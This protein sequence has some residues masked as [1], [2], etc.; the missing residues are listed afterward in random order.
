MT[1]DLRISVVI[2]TY[3]GFE[4]LKATI[5]SVLQ[6]TVPAAEI[7]V[8]DDGSTDDS[9][10]FQACFSRHIR[11]L[12]IANSGQQNARNHGVAQSTGDWIALLDHDDLWEPRYLA[13]VNAIVAAHAVDITICNSRTWQ[14]DQG[15][16]FWK[17]SNRFTQF[18]PDDYWRIVGASPDDRWSSLSRYDFA[19]YLN[20]HPAQT[21]MYCIRKSLYLS[22]G[23][24]DTRMRG[25]G[26][27]NFE[28]EMRALR[29]GRVGLIWDPLVTMCRHD[30]NAS[31]DG[32]R[33]TMDFVACLEFALHHHGLNA[34]ERA[35][36]QSVLHKRL[37]NAIDGAFTLG[38]YADIRRYRRQYRGRLPF[39]TA[40]KSAISE[41]PEALA[42][43][44]AGI[45]QE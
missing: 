12:K 25:S 28:F 38:K 36:V 33:M 8:I 24:F 29:A 42:R 40:L 9:T 4:R 16:G 5:N 23:G 2:P 19:S 1:N 17:D 34:G 35:I 32:N 11:Y 15:G 3:N 27:E 45:F 39:R 31:L 13:E 26:A 44:V 41:L 21:S 20:F 22:L 30:M 14:E 7:L 18:A 10:Q 6:Q 37:P 43:R